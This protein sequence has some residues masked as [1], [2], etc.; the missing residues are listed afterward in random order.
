ML[1]ALLALGAA[2]L[3]ACS[4][5]PTPASSQASPGNGIGSAENTVEAG[6]PS[7]SAEPQPVPGEEPL[8]TSAVKVT[9][10]EIAVVTT[11]KGVIK[12]A[13]YPK[14][15]PNTV[16]SFIELADKKFYDG[17]TWHRVVT[18]PE[19]FVIQGGDPLSKKLPAGD[20]RIGSGGPGW[21]LKAEFGTPQANGT[22][23]PAHKHLEGTVAL[24]RSQD[25]D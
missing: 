10:N 25:P 9:G 8:H 7:T 1:C 18:S 14:D 21:R 20:Q 11:N 15:A 2:M 4:Q 19:P 13:F 23:V 22:F 17:T 16:A 12:F 24:A 3:I 5:Q 6:E